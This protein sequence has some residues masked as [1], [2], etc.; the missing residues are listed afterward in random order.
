MKNHNLLWIPFTKS[1]YCSLTS[2]HQCTC[3]TFSMF[4]PSVVQ[5]FSNKKVFCTFP[6]ADFDEVWAFMVYS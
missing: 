6:F 2:C 4:V 3:A 5:S 1:Q